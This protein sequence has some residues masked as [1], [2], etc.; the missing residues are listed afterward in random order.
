MKRTTHASN[1][2]AQA[3]C[4]AAIECGAEIASTNIQKMMMRS[5]QELRDEG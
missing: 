4:V 1:P 5:S 3:I 2:Q